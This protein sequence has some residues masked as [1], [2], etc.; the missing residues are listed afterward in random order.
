MVEG[1]TSL[2]KLTSHFM[3]SLLRR[4]HG[5]GI[6]IPVTRPTPKKTCFIRQNST[7]VSESSKDT[8]TW[9][10]YLEIR[11]GKRRWETVDCSHFP[12][13]CYLLML[14][15]QALTIP[16]SLLGLVG[17]AAYFGSLET[18]ATKPIMVRS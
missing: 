4:S 1:G 2:A 17:G 7:T 14:Y 11:R 8:I 10:E 18:D 3:A 15:F 6:R 9:P 12:Q 13:N 5:R 16:S